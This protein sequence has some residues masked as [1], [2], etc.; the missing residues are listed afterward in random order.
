MYTRPMHLLEPHLP[1]MALQWR[2]GFVLPPLG[3]KQVSRQSP[4]SDF[5]QT[6]FLSFAL[7]WFDYPALPTVCSIWPETDRGDALSH[8][9][10]TIRTHFRHSGANGK[11]GLGSGVIDGRH[12]GRRLGRSDQ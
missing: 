1:E 8:R 3:L 9:D 7:R 11:D 5:H 6:Q 10:Y 4:E 12:A 2:Q